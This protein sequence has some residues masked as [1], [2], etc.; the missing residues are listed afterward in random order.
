MSCDGISMV[1][2]GSFVDPLGVCFG[3]QLADSRGDIRVIYA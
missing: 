3:Y 1:A 2:M